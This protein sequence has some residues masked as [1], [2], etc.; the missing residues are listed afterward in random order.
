MCIIDLVINHVKRSIKPSIPINSG[1]KPIAT[2]HS[3]TKP[4]TTKHSGTKLCSSIISIFTIY[5][6]SEFTIS[7]NCGSNSS[8]TKYSVAKHSFSI[9]SIS[10]Y[11]KSEYTCAFDT[12][13]N[14]TRANNTGTNTRAH[15][16]HNYQEAVSSRVNLYLF[17]NVLIT[18]PYL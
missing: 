15:N 14:N 17:K 6:T 16:T 10:I 7:L 5:A 4:V 13:T 3:G 12:R 8:I 11:P 9:N 2:E 1:T 18:F